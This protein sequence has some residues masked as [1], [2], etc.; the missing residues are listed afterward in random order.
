[1]IAQ[2]PMMPLV[3]VGLAVMMIPGAVP[4]APSWVAPTPTVLLL[5]MNVSVAPV[6]RA[7]SP[8][9]V[10]IGEPLS[11]VVTFRYEL[12]RTGVT[13]PVEIP[14]VRPLR[15]AHQTDPPN[16]S[17]G[18][19]AGRRFDTATSPVSFQ[20]SGVP[21]IVTPLVFSK[22]PRSWS[23]TMLPAMTVEPV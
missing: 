22:V 7:P 12:P 11:T 13:V 16:R 8:A 10:M 4:P 18:A 6:A 2:P 9:I 21:M 20:I 14:L 19:V 3:S 23:V 15:L 5:P 17:I 1:M